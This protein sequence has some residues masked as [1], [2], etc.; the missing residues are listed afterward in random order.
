MTEPQLWCGDCVEVL[1]TLEA[2]T[3][4][5]VITDPPYPEIDRDYG[6]MSES[7]WH[8]MMDVVV[9]EC[10]RILKPT[11]SAVFILQPNSERVGRMRPWLW[12]FMAKW[13][14]AWGMVQDA[15][16]WNV[17]A[18]PLTRNDP[19]ALRASM[20]ACV[21]FGP[22]DCY[23]EVGGVLW[24]ES[25]GNKARRLSGRCAMKNET[26][27]SRTNMV[28]ARARGKAGER[29][30]VQPFNVLPV[31]GER[32]AGVFGHGAATPLHLCDWW[33]RYICPDGGTVCDP[34]IGSGTVG[35]AAVKRGCNVIGIERMPKYF[36]IA[37]RRIADAQAARAELLIA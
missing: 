11:G 24:A 26:R 21:W 8:A 36:A 30:G 20:K 28:E 3:V 1:P 10:R 9:P 31:G 33:L 14:R 27:P 34:F 4:D 29:G 17:T 18:L 37:Q 7:N 32:L 13:T 19:N 12:E 5:C 22:P 25:D 2:G 15:W 35:I 6:R 16:W 23:H